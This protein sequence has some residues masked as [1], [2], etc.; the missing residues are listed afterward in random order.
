MK[1]YAFVGDDQVMEAEMM[2]QISKER[3]MNQ[4]LS[5]V[6]PWAKIA[7]NVVIEPFVTIHKNVK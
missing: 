6:H 4:P 7:D 2:A 3:L 5:F 1:G